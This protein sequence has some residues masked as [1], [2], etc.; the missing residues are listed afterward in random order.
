M[1]RTTIKDVAQQA[2]VSIT[3]VSHALSGGGVVKQETRERIQMLAREMNYI[4]NWNGRNLKSGDTNIIGFFIQYIRGFYG[5]IADAMYET[6]KE[7]GYELD[8]II[9]DDGNA[10]LNNLMSHRVDGAIILHENFR[11]DEVQALISTGLPAVFLER[12]MA[13]SRISSVLFDSYATGYEAAEY[14]YSLG[15]RKMMLIEGKNIYDGLER[16]RGFQDCLREKGITIEPAYRLFGDFNREEGFRQMEKFIKSGLPMPT[17]IFAEND[18]SAF[19]CMTAL[20]NAGYSIPEDVSVLGCDNVELAEWWVPALTSMDT[21]ISEQGKK[22]AE[23]IV[24]L[25]KGEKEGSILKTPSKLISR[26]SC[27]RI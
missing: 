7:L 5:Q 24:A 19:G 13:R 1:K 2:G 10:I 15:H 25:V 3:T 21:M 26:A 14:L 9:V 12:E 17:A 11:E 23:E 20:T 18:D 6:L 4:P 16:S 8:I 27:A 22:A